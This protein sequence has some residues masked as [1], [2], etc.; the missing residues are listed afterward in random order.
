MNHPQ[1]KCQQEKAATIAFPYKGKTTSSSFR[2]LKGEV[3]NLLIGVHLLLT[4]SVHDGTAEFG[5]RPGSSD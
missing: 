4:T 2:I 1:W 3:Y 5:R